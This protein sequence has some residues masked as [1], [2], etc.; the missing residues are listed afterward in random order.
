M[1]ETTLNYIDHVRQYMSKMT[2]HYIDLV[3]RLHV[4]KDVELK[5]RGKQL[6]SR[7]NER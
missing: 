1:Y 6:I 4:W 3:R 2:L 7:R 5:K